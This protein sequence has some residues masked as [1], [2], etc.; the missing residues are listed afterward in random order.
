[1][2]GQMIRERTVLVEGEVANVFGTAELR[3]D[4]AGKDDA[5]SVLCYTANYVDRLGRWR[6]LARQTVPRTAK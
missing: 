3:L 4:V 1:M 5:I 2:A 6:M